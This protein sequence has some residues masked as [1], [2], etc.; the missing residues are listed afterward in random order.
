MSAFKFRDN[1][2]VIKTKGLVYKST[3]TLGIQVINKTGADIAANK[4]VA[5]TGYD[6][7]SKRVKVVLADA[8]VAAHD[9][10]YV[11]KEIISNGKQGHVYKGFLS[12]ATLD[13]SSVTTVG[14][15]LYLHTS[16]GAFTATAPTASNAM[17][18]PVGFAAVKSSTVGQIF[19]Q[20][21]PRSVI[22]SNQ[23]QTGAGADAS[24]VTATGTIA[25][26]DITGTSAGQL[27]HANG[28][29]LV[30]AQGATKIV[31]LVYALIENDFSV[32][33]Y[34]GGGNTTINISAGGAAVSGLVSNANF[35]QA[36]ADK[37]I[38]FVPLAATFNVYTLNKGLNLVTASAPTQPGTAAG[39]FGYTVG[40]RILTTRLD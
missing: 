21:G 15:P 14:D 29:P 3:T 32:A 35:I 38:E 2:S 1:A 22:G 6:V 17:A 12:P 5:V 8:D 7:T 27:G 39:V 25:S 31:Q 37:S 34:G 28:Y 18:V 10:I 11:T 20:I 4:L 9:D 23:F 33:A 19:W 16:A 30:A 13:T 36:A 24:L 40:Y 26:A